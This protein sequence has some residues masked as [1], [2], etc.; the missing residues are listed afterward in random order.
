MV[1]INSLFTT[2]PSAPTVSLPWC[3]SA[4]ASLQT[5]ALSALPLS[6]IAA[7]S[8]PPCHERKA[9]TFLFGILGPAVNQVSSNHWW[10]ADKRAQWKTGRYTETM[11]SASVNVEAKKTT[12][13]T[14]AS[15]RSW[16][17]GGAVCSSLSESS[18]MSWSS[19]KRFFHWFLMLAVKR[20]SCSTECGARV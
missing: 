15:H 11:T 20:Y 9:R 6:R 17:R 2:A 19:L 1:M 12:E 4:L 3:M 10:H 14:Q 18:V 8:A 13:K 5:S 16:P 7:F